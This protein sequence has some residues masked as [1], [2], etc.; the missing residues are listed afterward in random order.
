MPVPDGS[1]CR[2]GGDGSA[3]GHEDT[4]DDVLDDEVGVVGC[5]CCCCCC[6]RGGT[7]DVAG[8]VGL[9]S[10]CRLLLL[11]DTMLALLLLEL[12]AEEP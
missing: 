7:E 2:G 5:C 6:C 8:V 3:L 10:D 9:F 4:A 12:G 11:L 1:T